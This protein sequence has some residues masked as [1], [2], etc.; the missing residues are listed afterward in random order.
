MK[1]P[2]DVRLSYLEESEELALSIRASDLHRVSLKLLAQYYE[3]QGDHYRALTYLK[4]AVD[5]VLTRERRYL[6]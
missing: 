3:N 5:S 6:E 2:P 1:L 4:K